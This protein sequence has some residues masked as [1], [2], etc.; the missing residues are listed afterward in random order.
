MNVRFVTSDEIRESI[1]ALFSD[2]IRK[3]QRLVPWATIDHV[4]GTAVPGLRTKGDLDICVRV[5]AEEFEKAV[6][7]LRA[8][9]EVN[10][11][12]NWTPTYA[13]FKDDSRDLGIQLCVRDSVDDYF[14]A[15]RDYLRENPD[16][17]AELNTLKLKYEGAAMDAYREA[18][19]DFFRSL[20]LT[21]EN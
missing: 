21:Y 2:E 11:V 14:V 5:G 12:H 18:K 9:Y 15:Q 17:V 16:A 19:N 1:E 8:R 7:L 4:G 10:Q 3:L 6:E 13:S 20:K